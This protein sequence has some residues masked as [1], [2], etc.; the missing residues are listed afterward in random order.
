MPP[1]KNMLR[2]VP[3]GRVSPIGRS[4]NGLTTPNIKMSATTSPVCWNSAGSL[5]TN[6]ERRQPK[7]MFSTWLTI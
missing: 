1:S 5:R 7:N 4:M 3:N 6:T 2:S